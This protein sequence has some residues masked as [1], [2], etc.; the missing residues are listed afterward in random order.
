MASMN[1]RSKVGN[2][3]VLRVQSTVNGVKVV[4]YDGVGMAEGYMGKR[5]MNYKYGDDAEE[6]AT[7]YAY[8][9]A[10]QIRENREVPVVVVEL[11]EVMAEKLEKVHAER[12]DGDEVAGNE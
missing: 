4:K 6:K 7:E 3:V 9:K 5:N 11:G 2:E 10:E 12:D 8:N 1:D